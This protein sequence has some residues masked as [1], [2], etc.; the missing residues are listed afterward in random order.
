MNFVSLI[1]FAFLLV[2]VLVYFLLPHKI[3]W[4]WLLLASYFFYAFSSYWLAFLI[5]S[6]TLVC[7]LCALGIE[8][9][10]R[11]SK[12]FLSLSLIISLGALFV[13]KYLNFTIQT[14]SF[15]VKLAGN[16]RGFDPLDII[17]PVGISFYTFQALSYVVDVY[18]GRSKVE[19]HFGYFALFVSYFPQLVAGP[20]ER[21]DALMPQL[22]EEHRFDSENF[23]TGFRYMLI[24]YFKKVV[25]ADFLAIFVNRVYGDIPGHDGTA[26]ILAT[27][28]FAFQI[29]GDFS[30]YSD[31]ARGTSKIMG[32]DL[33][34][35]FDSPYMA[36][37]I[38]DFW[39]R[40]HISLTK[41]F[42]D[43]VYIPLGGSK[44]GK[45][46]HCLNV[47]IVFL[48]SGLWH[49]ADLKFVVWGAL[50]GLFLIIGI[51]LPKSNREKGKMLTWASRIGTFLLVCFAW[52]FFRANSLGEAWSAIT[53]IFSGWNIQGGLIPMIE[54]S[55]LLRLVV[56]FACFGLI[57]YVPLISLKEGKE[58]NWHAL[59]AVGITMLLIG[60]SWAMNYASG[61]GSAFIYFQF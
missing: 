55:F 27:V 23:L 34:Q 15:F 2:T 35:N 40:W 3:R 48:L 4:A 8:R 36:T 38:R 56:C 47:M 37:S 20:I 13:F 60:L 54:V 17:L 42:T 51:M 22:K 18:R 19:R 46:R 45:F 1:F 25:I 43:Y 61:G 58:Q 12:L 52:V 57:G 49:G 33:M 26:I 14:V 6:V 10:P 31:I 50:H 53:K 41:W 11:K 24:G 29:Y 21:F 16:G 59:G 5:F 30:G 28:L 7:Y 44:K 39:R 32:I 9:F